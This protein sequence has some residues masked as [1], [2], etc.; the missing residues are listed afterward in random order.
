MTKGWGGL[1]ALGRPNNLMDNH[2]K[3]QKLE[4]ELQTAT[5]A[6]RRRIIRELAQ[7]SGRRGADT[8][9]RGEEA[10]KR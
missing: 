7:L 10:N 9:P 1:G 3:R 2:Q 8:R 6:D 4:A 5:A